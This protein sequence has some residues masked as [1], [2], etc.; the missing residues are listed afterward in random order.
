MILGESKALLDRA[1]K[2]IDDI[3][4]LYKESVK[5]KVIKDDIKIEIKNFLENCR[6]AL[7][8]AAYYI[9]S[10]I[11]ADNF[12]DEERERKE[13][14]VDFPVKYSLNSFENFLKDYYPNLK[15]VAPKI[16]EVFESCQP[17]KKVTWTK[18][19]NKLLNSNKHRKFSVQDR[20]VTNHI[21]QMTLGGNYFENVTISGCAVPIAI[22]G[23]P[24][25]LM[26]PHPMVS[27]LHATI[28]VDFIFKDLNI[29]VIP[30]LKDIHSKVT[31]IIDEL[32][33][34]LQDLE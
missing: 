25:D 32:E 13:Q 26:N 19:F 22:N 17:F 8:F 11:S 10:K 12:S 18:T 34:I 14:Y 3:E 20:K 28:T 27:S 24:Y 7:D 4:Q 16:N 21:H 1:N 6:S 31:F 33:K 2:S 15:E 30:T 23:V 29:P 9:F 5:S